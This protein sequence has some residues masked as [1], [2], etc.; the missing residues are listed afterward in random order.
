MGAAR[1]I[2]FSP[3]AEPAICQ[4]VLKFA[5]SARVPKFFPAH[6]FTER[7]AIGNRTTPH[8]LEHI[9]NPMTA[10]EKA[11]VTIEWEHGAPPPALR[12]PITGEVVLIG[13]DPAT[14]AY[15]DGVEEPDFASIPTVLF[16]Y[17][18]EV[19]DFD[20]I[21]DDLAK[22][23]EQKR[24]DLGDDGEDLDDFEILSEHL[25]TI[26]KVPLVFNLITY[27]MACGPVSGSVYVGLDLAGSN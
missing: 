19:G 6:P 23:I 13:Y 16:S 26:G 15:V 10:F 24:A 8:S 22:A 9:E 18:P 7:A 17:I 4:C 25:E 2:A 5:A 27:G 21:R 3:P 12:C 14:G 11:L 20:F 1:P